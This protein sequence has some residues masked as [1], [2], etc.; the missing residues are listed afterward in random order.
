VFPFREQ[1]LQELA[2]HLF[3]N[4]MVLGAYQAVAILFTALAG[5]A[6]LIGM[7]RPT[8]RH[9]VRGAALIALLG[10]TLYAPVSRHLDVTYRHAIFV[11]PFFAV[12]I[13]SGAISL[14]EFYRRAMRGVGRP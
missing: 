9:I 12:V 5:L 1:R 8:V 11:L 2:P 4:A 14:A 3:S 7:L 10:V 13:G 6:F